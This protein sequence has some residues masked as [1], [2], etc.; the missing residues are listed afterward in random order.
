MRSKQTANVLELQHS[1]NDFAPPSVPFSKTFTV[2]LGYIWKTML[3][4][5]LRKA[6][7]YVLQKEL[8][9]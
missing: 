7:T 1:K 9:P 8:G 5:H 3:K 2:G 6:F 4:N